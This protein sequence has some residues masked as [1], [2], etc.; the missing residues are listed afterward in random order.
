MKTTISLLLFALVIAVIFGFAGSKSS[1]NPK[2]VTSVSNIRVD[3]NVIT[4][5]EFIELIKKR[6]LNDRENSIGYLKNAKVGWVKKS[7]LDLLIPLIRSTDTCKCV[8]SLLSSSNYPGQYSILGGFAIELINSYRFNVEFPEQ[9]YNCPR[10][11]EEK[12][13]EIERWLV[14]RSK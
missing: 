10:T 13:K 8:I 1:L 2:E 5:K 4:V 7:D 6:K 14:T 11:E 12:I 9:L 3:F